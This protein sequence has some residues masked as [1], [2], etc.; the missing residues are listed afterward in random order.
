MIR[1][2][3]LGSKQAF[4]LLKITQNPSFRDLAVSMIYG[5]DKNIEELTQFLAKKTETPKIN[6]SPESEIN[7]KTREIKL[8]KKELEI[9]G[10]ELEFQKQWIFISGASLSGN[11][12]K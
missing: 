6:E 7:I 5:V 1:A 8:Q 12:V 3:D 9:Q 4:N 11:L 10:K 2:H